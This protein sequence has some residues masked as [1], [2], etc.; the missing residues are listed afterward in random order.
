MD[1]IQDQPGM[2]AERITV[3]ERQ[4]CRASDIVFTTSPDL[5]AA[6][7]KYNIHTYHYGNVADHEHFGR[8]VR[9]CLSPPSEIQ[10]I[11]RPRLIFIGAI[12][13]G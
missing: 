5:Q 1:R 2:P 8:A 9:D 12:S 13:I 6:L 4:L 11:P 3:G 10:A 7:E